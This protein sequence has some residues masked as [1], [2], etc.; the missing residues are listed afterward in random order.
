V[1][2]IVRLAAARTAE[3]V[4]G[5]P[6]YR[7]R[8]R[9]LPL[10]F[11]DREL[12]LESGAADDRQ[13]VVLQAGEGQF[14]LVVD[15]VHDIEGIVVKPLGAPLSAIACFGGAA[16]LGD[17]QVVLFLGVMGLVRISTPS[18]SRILN[19]AG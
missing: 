18:D 1:V 3:E 14:G 17:G 9:L 7:L 19:S 6:V 2:E 15:A 11:L 5:A 12:H 4:G 8:D 13:V 10:C 16:V